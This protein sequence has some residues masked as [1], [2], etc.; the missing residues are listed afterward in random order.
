MVGTRL[1]IKRGCMFMEGCFLLTQDTVHLNP[2]QTNTKLVKKP[3]QKRVKTS[4]DTDSRSGV[5]SNDFSAFSQQQSSRNEVKFD[6]GD[7]IKLTEEDIQNEI[8]DLFEMDLTEY[9]K[10]LRQV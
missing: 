4:A 8:D 1:T 3:N 9:E 5:Y 2:P 10:N 6:I 7:G